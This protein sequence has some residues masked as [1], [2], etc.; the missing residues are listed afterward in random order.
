MTITG[1][2]ADSQEL[3]IDSA[4]IK[5]EEEGV[6]MRTTEVHTLAKNTGLSW[7]EVALDQMEAQPITESTE[8]V[9]PQ[10]YVDSLFTIT[11]TMIGISTLVTDR[12][13]ARIAKDTIAKMGALKQNAIQRKKDEDY[14]TVL[15][16]GSTAAAPG[17]NATLTS[18]HLSAMVSRIRGNTTE[19]SRT[20][21][22]FLVMHP[23]QI[24]DIQDEIVAGVGTYAVPQ[25]MTESVF[26]NGYEGQLFGFSVFAAGN[27]TIDSDADAKGGAHTREAIVMVQGR[28]PWSKTKDRPEVGGGATELFMYDEYAFGER[29]AGN[30]LYEIYSDA[31]APT[32]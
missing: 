8:L 7:E 24:K 10:Q 12:V 23:F 3:I 22:G 20:S 28:S 27:I 15:D 5:R 30:W 9:N 18:G 25:G 13:Y 16:G 4:R 14:I 29:S 1:S 17:A 32:S 2:L 19:T 26:R 31:T 11:P 21:P 6:F